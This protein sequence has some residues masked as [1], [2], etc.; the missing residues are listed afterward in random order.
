MY[1]YFL[2]VIHINLITLREIAYEC[3]LCILIKKTSIDMLLCFPF[4]STLPRMLFV[5]L[6]IMLPVAHSLSLP[7]EIDA[8]AL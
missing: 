3:N 5:D 6:L 4:G 8:A 2:R 7:K 1:I